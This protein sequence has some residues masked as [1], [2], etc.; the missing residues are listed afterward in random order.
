M[1]L[2]CQQRAAALIARQSYDLLSTRKTAFSVI[3]FLLTASLHFLDRL[4]LSFLF[5]LASL[6]LASPPLF[7]V[8]RKPLLTPPQIIRGVRYKKTVAISQRFFERFKDVT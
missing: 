4:S 1:S 3:N 8:H 7:L 5:L 2:Y 6:F